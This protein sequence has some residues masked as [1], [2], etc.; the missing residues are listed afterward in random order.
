MNL[1]SSVGLLASALY[2]LNFTVTNGQLAGLVDSGEACCFALLYL[3]LSIRRSAREILAISALGVLGGL[4]KETFVPLAG[5]LALGWRA[6]EGLKVPRRLR[7][8]LVEPALIVGLGFITIISVRYMYVG[9][10]VAPWEM[11]EEFARPKNLFARFAGIFGTQLVYVFGWLLP[12]AIVG[13]HVVPSKIRA[14]VAASAALAILLGVHNDSG[15]NV[16]RAIF[17]LGGPAFCLAAAHAL[18]R[19]A[20]VEESRHC[21]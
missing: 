6:A 18:S 20:H 4:A 10:W 13:F 17:N 2:L 7:Y 8:F 16:A 3:L 19:L 15:G 21:T 12:L 9:R 1:D 14:G 11:V 5:A